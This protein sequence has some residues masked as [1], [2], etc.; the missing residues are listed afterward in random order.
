M[1]NKGAQLLNGIKR[2]G[3]FDK[4]LASQ[5]PDAYKKFWKEWKNTEPTAVHYI[6]KEGKWERDE[7]TGQVRTVQNIPIPVIYPPEH[8][9][10]S[11]INLFFN[12][13]NKYNFF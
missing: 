6:P 13:K 4:G 12:F 5:L 11:F 8:N 3:R 7:I 1:K 2:V 9:E 10:V